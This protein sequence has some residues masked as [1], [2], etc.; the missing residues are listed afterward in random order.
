MSDQKQMSRQIRLVEK[1]AGKM[2][3]ESAGT[4]AWLRARDDYLQG[5]DYFLDL[6]E[7]G[8]DPESA[9]S[10]AERPLIYLLCIQAPL[11]LIHA[12]GFHPFKIFSGS[13]A[14]GNLSAHGLPTLICPL[15]KS[16]LGAMQMTGNKEEQPWILPTTCDWVVKFPEMMTLFGAAEQRLHWLE[17]PH[18]KEARESQGLWLDEMVK[19]KGFLEQLSGRK[20]SRNALLDSI[21]VYHRAWQALS[22]LVLLRRQGLLSSA[23]FLLI[24]NTFFLDKVENWTAALEKLLPTLSCSVNSAKRRI[25]LAG[26]PIFF[27]N[28]KLPRLLEEAGLCVTGD[29]ICSGERLFPGGVSFKDSSVFGL[30]EALAQRYHQGCLC[31][32]FADNQRRIRNIEAQAEYFDGVVFHV[33]KGCHP[34]DL[35]SYTIESGLKKQGIKFIRLE[36]DHASEDSQ[37]LLTRLEAYSHTLPS[38]GLRPPFP[39]ERGEGNNSPRPLAGEG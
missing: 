21:A 13:F 1:T 24:T 34:Y 27:P 33:L 4:L 3:Q 29:D 20:I 22:R 14:A 2:A 38:S 28:F 9:R 15:M 25:F 6:A 26:S 8:F 31:P 37:N 18:I 12:A 5:F 11:E 35:E 23:W 39:R 10:K 16:I 17:L 7:K 32:T 36:T 19:L 30:I